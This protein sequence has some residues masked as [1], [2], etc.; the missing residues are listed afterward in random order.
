MP[1][2]VGRGVFSN[3]TMILTGAYEIVLDFVLRFGE[4]N[5]IVAR[6]ILP[7]V[8]ARQLIA[9]LQENLQ[10]FETRFGPVPRLP[11]VRQVQEET[12]PPPPPEED[13]GPAGA[14]GMTAAQHP[15]NMPQSPAQP[16]IED[17][18]DELRLPDAMLSGSY[19]NA[20]LVRHTG[21]EFCFDFITNIFP[22]SAVSA[23]VYLA[24]PHVPLL[25][26]SLIRSLNPGPDPGRN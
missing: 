19:A 22:R 12:P 23:R 5:R 4:P 1:E 20:V 14:G 24:A 11:R 18:Y 8:V 7:H 16:Q 9:V 15:E 2:A 17:I 25:L 6:V 26:Q 21:T 3:G 10:A 13:P